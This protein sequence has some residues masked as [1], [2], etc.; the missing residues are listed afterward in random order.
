MFCE[1]EK[2]RKTE[3]NVLAY[4]VRDGYPVTNLHTLAIPERHVGSHF[5]TRSSRNERLHRQGSAGRRRRDIET[6]RR[7]QLSAA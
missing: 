2:S 4:M 7:H 1:V 3:D 5:E 6:T